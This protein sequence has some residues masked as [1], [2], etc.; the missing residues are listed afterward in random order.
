[1]KPELPPQI[2]AAE[3]MAAALVSD[4][5]PKPG[6]MARLDQQMDGWIQG[7]NPYDPKK[8]QGRGI[9]P[10]EITRLGQIGGNFSRDIICH[11]LSWRDLTSPA[12]LFRR[13]LELLLKNNARKDAMLFLQIPQ[14]LR[15]DRRDHARIRKGRVTPR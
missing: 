9:E 4:A 8:L 10:G 15:F 6:I 11:A 2:Q 13:A 1:M 7:W 14:V 5:V 3:G 12:R